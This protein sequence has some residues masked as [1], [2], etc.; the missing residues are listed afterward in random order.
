V[1][2]PTGSNSLVAGA[3]SRKANGCLLGRVGVGGRKNQEMLK[4]FPLLFRPLLEKAPLP[5][6][7]SVQI[8]SSAPHRIMIEV[9]SC[10][11]KLAYLQRSAFSSLSQRSK[12]LRVAPV[13]PRLRRRR[14]Q[15]ELTRRR[16]I[17][18]RFRVPKLFNGRRTTLAVVRRVMTSTFIQCRL[19][20][21]LLTTR[22]SRSQRT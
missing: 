11:E 7:S 17:P 15:T 12:E 21:T 10:R 2:R 16:Q 4:G 13:W 20:Q 6:R 14:T 22:R 9:V 3:V 19:L 8:W 5:Y 18:L 1:L